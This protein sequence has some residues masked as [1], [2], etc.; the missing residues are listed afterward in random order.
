MG[1]CFAV[2][3]WLFLEMGGDWATLWPS[4]HWGQ[5]EST[6]AWTAAEGWKALQKKAGMGSGYVEDVKLWRLSS[7]HCCDRI[8][9]ATSLIFIF[10]VLLFLLYYSV[11][12]MPFIGPLFCACAPCTFLLSKYFSGSIFPGQS[13]QEKDLFLWASSC[14]LWTFL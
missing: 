5:W 14:I 13:V 2:Q 1:T 10:S 7:Q 9:W 4:R 3:G 8:T 11:L 6:E 12:K